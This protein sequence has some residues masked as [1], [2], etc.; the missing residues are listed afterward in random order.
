[1]KKI[2]FTLLLPVACGAGGFY[3][4]R[5]QLLTGFE[6]TGLAVPGNLYAWLLIA[7]SL[8]V[9]AACLLL[10]LRRGR[11]PQSYSEAF[12]STGNAFY[13]F[14]VALAALLLLAAGAAGL[15]AFR[16]QGGTWPGLL[17]WCLCLVSAV[18]VLVAA[19][20]NFRYRGR[21][22]TGGKGEYSLALLALPYTACLWLVTAYQEVFAE[23]VT[24]RYIYRI[25]AII[26]TLL[27]VYF[28]AGF[29]F[30]RPRPRLCLLFSLMG[31]YLSIVSLAD[32]G[33]W[34][35]RLLLL[36][37]V[38]YLSHTALILMTNILLPPPEEPPR[39]PAGPEDALE[40]I[41]GFEPGDA[42]L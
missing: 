42:I 40:D 35:T 6:S 33:N 7:L 11:T 9:A 31:I 10:C 13:L 14:F 29:A 15:W 19:L 39:P 32:G 37:S 22:R 1:M 8:L 28:I 24:L 30:Q 3:L 20:N 16:S 12:S 34:P 17:Q 2:L 27:A 26:C 38:L 18:C 4:R 21:R 25:L 5:Q 41:P 23:P 36:A